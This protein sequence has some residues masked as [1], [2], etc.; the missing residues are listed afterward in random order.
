MKRKGCGKSQAAADADKLA[1]VRGCTRAEVERDAAQAFAR[2]NAA[3]VERLRKELADTVREAAADTAT[4]AQAVTAAEMWKR[5][6]KR[7]RVKAE[8]VAEGAVQAAEAAARGAAAGR[9]REPGAVTQAQLCALVRRAGGKLSADTIQRCR[10][11][12]P[13]KSIPYNCRDIDAATASLALAVEWAKTVAE[14]QRCALRVKVSFDERT[15]EHN[16]RK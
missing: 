13:V 5:Y 10:Q 7:R 12:K 1:K 3:E 8:A 14:H 6:E 15:T 2:V 4:L 16:T 9:Q 11:G